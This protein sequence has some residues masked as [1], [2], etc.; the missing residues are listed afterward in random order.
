MK[1]LAALVVVA[2]V[3]LAACGDGSDGTAA[4]TES[5]TTTAETTPATAPATT[6]QPEG[7]SLEEAVRA[8]T[9][10]FLGGDDQAAYDL[11]SERCHGAM[12]SAE[13]KSIVDQATDLYGGETIATYA[14]DVNGNTATVTY[15]LTDATLNQTNERWVFEGNAWHNDEC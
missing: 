4:T 8:Y 11:L 3:V 15:E 7:P 1:K 5:P 2:S 6:T 9:A 13:F 12:A 14:E 10:A